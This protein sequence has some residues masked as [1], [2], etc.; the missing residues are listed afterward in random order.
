M[1]HINLR[2]TNPTIIQEGLKELG[3]ALVVDLADHVNLPVATVSAVLAELYR[4]HMVHIF[5]WARN[6]QGTPIKIYGWG[7]GDDAK[8]PLKTSKPKQKEVVDV[9]L[10]WPRCDVAAS[11]IRTTA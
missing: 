7:E 4:R 8:Q 5:G 9:Q 6:K 10:P 11:W 1:P 2:A 3:E